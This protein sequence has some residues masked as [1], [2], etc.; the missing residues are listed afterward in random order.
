MILLFIRNSHLQIS[1][2]SKFS[3]LK[4]K[5]QGGRKIRF[6]P[7][8]N[9]PDRTRIRMKVED[10]NVCVYVCSQPNGNNRRQVGHPNGI[11]VIPWRGT[12]VAQKVYPGT[13]VVFQRWRITKHLETVP[14]GS[15]SERDQSCTNVTAGQ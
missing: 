13:V 9:S 12:K 6:S 5:K 8:T 14:K 2:S 3:N 15:P 4:E 1:R 7:D 10:S 11:I